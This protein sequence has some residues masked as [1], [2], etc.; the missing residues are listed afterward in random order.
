M[1]NIK[2]QILITIAIYTVCYLS[3]SFIEW[4]LGNPFQWVVDMPIY[5]PVDRFCGLFLYLI[6]QISLW[7]II[8][9]SK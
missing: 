3:K 5:K 9:N 8:N 6:Y 7:A 4:D 2:K 1:K